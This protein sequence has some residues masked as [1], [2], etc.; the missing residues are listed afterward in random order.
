MKYCRTQG[1]AVAFPRRPVQGVE[2]SGDA[3]S[4]SIRIGSQSDEATFG[5]GIGRRRMPQRSGCTS[6]ASLP[7]RTNRPGVA[8]GRCWRRSPRRCRR[9]PRPHGPRA[10]PIPVVELRGD[11]ADLGTEHG[12]RLRDSIH[13]L[14]D[15]YLKRYL[16]S[17]RTVPRPQGRDFFRGRIGADY[18]AE[19]TVSPRLRPRPRA[20]RC[21]P[22][23]SSTLPAWSPVPRSHSRRK[24]LRTTSPAS[25]GTSTSPRSTSPTSTR[26]LRYHPDGSTPS[27]PS[28]G[29][30]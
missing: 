10:V 15:G 14:H 22:S 4:C 5:F 13:T 24:R 26:P 16:R 29:R 9:P 3:G 23:V 2:S 27:R 1:P 8:P 28:A 21:S 12:Q 17:D 20:R 18:G 19:A 25:G 7:A 11:S 6:V 30:G